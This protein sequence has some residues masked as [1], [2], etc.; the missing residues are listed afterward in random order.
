MSYI[1][2]LFVFY[3]DETRLVEVS[4]CRQVT[5]LPFVLTIKSQIVSFLSVFFCYNIGRRQYM[6]VLTDYAKS[7]QQTVVC[8]CATH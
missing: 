4:T 6:H 5:G 8:L 2:N 1:K 3:L 7:S